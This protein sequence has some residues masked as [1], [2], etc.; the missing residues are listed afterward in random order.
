M[1]TID[2]DDLDPQGQPRNRASVSEPLGAQDFSMNYF[3]LD[4]G[5]E[6]TTSLHTHLDQEEAFL[7]LE[8]EATFETKPD[9]DAESE[10][11]RVSEGQI[12]RFDPGEYQQGRNES[13]ERTRVLA[14]GTPQESTDARI[15]A[16]CQNCGDTEYLALAMVDG[17]PALECPECGTQVEA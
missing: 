13:E 1:E 8:G 10:T 9:L 17:E 14:L 11:V 2:T 3:E 5:E 12:V 6:L 16:P 15:A 4:P 7:V